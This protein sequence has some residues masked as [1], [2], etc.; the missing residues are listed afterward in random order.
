VL[1]AQIPL[2]IDPN[3]SPYYIPD[4]LFI[5]ANLNEI[6]VQLIEPLLNWINYA[7]EKRDNSEMLN[8]LVLEMFEDITDPKSLNNEEQTRPTVASFRSSS[9][10]I[11]ESASSSSINLKQRSIL[12]KQRAASVVKGQQHHGY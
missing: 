9:T 4:P 11:I 10:R 5:Y 1:K 3:D 7:P 6:N 8:L 2:K 12:A